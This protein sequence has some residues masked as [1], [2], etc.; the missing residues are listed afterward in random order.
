MREQFYGTLSPV[1]VSPPIYRALPTRKWY[2]HSIPSS[3]E[4]KWSCSFRKMTNSDVISRDSGI[5]REVKNPLSNKPHWRSRP[6]PF[7]LTLHPTTPLFDRKVHH[8]QERQS[9]MSQQKH[10]LT[11]I[12]FICQIISLCLKEIARLQNTDSTTTVHVQ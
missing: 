4:T 6:F 10:F 8:C 9:W 1:K 3:L 12:T 7:P 2:N 11:M 5:G